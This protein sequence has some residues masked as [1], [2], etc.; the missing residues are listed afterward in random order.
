[1]TGDV[2]ESD[3]TNVHYLQSISYEF[4]S[5]SICATK[6]EELFSLPGLS[7]FRLFHHC[8]LSLQRPRDGKSLLSVATATTLSRSG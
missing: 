8:L 1:M 6:G 2:A 7:F 5:G 3:K 4:D